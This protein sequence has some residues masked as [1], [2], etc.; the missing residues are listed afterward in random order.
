[1]RSRRALPMVAATSGVALLLAG[2]GSDPWEEQQAP[3]EEQQGEGGELII[4]SQAYYSNE[5][6]AEIYAQVLETEGFDVRR[7]FQ[8]GQRDVYIEA[9]ENGEVQLLPEYTGNLL[10]YYEED[11]SARSSDEISEEL[12]GALPDELEVLELAPAEDTDSY[13]VSADFAEENDVSSLS[14]L[15]DYDGD[16][17][18]GGNAELEQ[19]P[20]G[21]DGLA[22]F[23]DLDVSFTAIGDSGGPLTQEAI[24][25]GSITLGDIY[26]ADPVLGSGDFISLDDPE[27]MILA[28]NVVPLITTDFA[29]DVAPVLDPVSAELTTDE[30][31]SL[32]ARSQEEELDS[33]NIASDWLEEHDLGG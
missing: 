29:E 10:Q 20:Y 7:Q 5:I 25:D 24:S 17:T 26:T 23:Y 18:V 1:M 3:H 31:I 12:P 27:N 13:A 28:Q 8:I 30:L 6:I 33:A 32:N 16:I 2:C 11:T 9:L 14:D 15:S 21:P 4:G 22:E 19:R